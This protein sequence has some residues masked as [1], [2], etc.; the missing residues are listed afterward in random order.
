M[1]EESPNTPLNESKAFDP[2]DAIW[3]TAKDNIQVKIVERTKTAS[4]KIFYTI[5]GSGAV[6]PEDQVEFLNNPDDEQAV[7]TAE[8]SQHDFK[9]GEEVTLLHKGKEQT[10]WVVDEQDDYYPG[11]VKIKKKDG[12]REG[13][14]A[15]PDRLYKAE[16]PPSD[17]EIKDEEMTE[18]VGKIATGQVVE[19]PEK[20]KKYK[21]GEVEKVPLKGGEKSAII[22]K[23][24]QE[25][26]VVGE[27]EKDGK[28][29]VKLASGREIPKEDIES[30]RWPDD[31]EGTE[32]ILVR[33]RGKDEPVFV[34]KDQG[35]EFSIQYPD[36]IKLV[37]L[38]GLDKNGNPEIKIARPRELVQQ[39]SLPQGYWRK[40]LSEAEKPT[41]V[42]P[43]KPEE[44]DKESEQK[45]KPEVKNKK[46]DFKFRKGE[47]V[48]VKTK[49]RKREFDW[50][51][52]VSFVGKNNVVFVKLEDPSGKLPERVRPQD[53]LLE[54]NPR[55]GA[56]ESAPDNSPA[57][58]D[59][60]S[61]DDAASDDGGNDNND[62]PEVTHNFDENSWLDPRRIQ[63]LYP[64]FQ[65]MLEEERKNF[66]APLNEE[67]AIHHESI[68]KTRVL[69]RLISN[70]ISSQSMTVNG[71][72]EDS[73]R[74]T[75]GLK[76]IYP[77]TEFTIPQAPPE[78]VKQQMLAMLDRPG[79]EINS[80]ATKY[81][82]QLS[83]EGTK[84]KIG[85][86]VKVENNGGTIEDG[87]RV[88]GQ[89][90]HYNMGPLEVIV[91]KGKETRYIAPDELRKWQEY[92]NP[93]QEKSDLD[94][95][96]PYFNKVVKTKQ[97]GG[98]VILGRVGYSTTKHKVYIS[99]PDG[100][101][102]PDLV[103]V[104]EFLSWQSLKPD[105]KI[106]AEEA[107]E[108]EK[109]D[110][111]APFQK[112]TVV[113][114]MWPDG[115]LEEGWECVDVVERGNTIYITVE[116]PSGIDDQI[117]YGHLKQWQEETVQSTDNANANTTDTPTDT[118]ATIN[119]DN[120]LSRK[121]IEAKKKKEREAKREEGD[122]AFSLW[123]EKTTQKWERHGLPYRLATGTLGFFAL[124]G[125]ALA[126]PVTYPSYRIWRTRLTEK[127]RVEEANRKKKEEEEDKKKKERK[128]AEEENANN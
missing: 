35:I 15:F 8:E 94:K 88:E 100:Q 57:E 49:D 120:K 14:Y 24:G 81:D 9:P 119:V 113:K 37:Y 53:L 128:K 99:G 98:E 127:M 11:M 58:N 28:T 111:V 32:F 21:Y 116:D 108:K 66:T 90:R 106:A 51:V 126:A 4:G 112:G 102:L 31:F 117:E 50:R 92:A 16:S 71:I 87:W 39:T 33:D 64:K 60:V 69:E 43:P 72:G 1:S 59:V 118:T 3:H 86:E 70:E 27:A 93:D 7:E 65:A 13:T 48:K 40:K 67:E 79:Q 75:K 107:A 23:G 56:Q 18:D 103:D 91:S 78:E 17:T 73:N 42:Q 95:L 68:L 80:L 47:I 38:E 109:W 55:P 41:N 63:E 77:N 12:T 96:K 54:W 104:D 46:P 123:L 115:T 114:V 34:V 74:R 22:S 121:E 62:S 44:V 76:D 61:P 29:Y 10:G 105:A 84:F 122:K 124:G 19:D 36:G 82:E 6:V 85:Q 26:V 89:R 25:V 97:P 125:A 45:S 5:E 20:P 110:K 101:W 83:K 2:K 30:P 52:G